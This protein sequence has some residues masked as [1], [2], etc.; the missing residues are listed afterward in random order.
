MQPALDLIGGHIPPPRW[1]RGIPSR[2]IKF[3]YDSG[4][5]GKG[6]ACFLPVME[7][8]AANYKSDEPGDR[9]TPGFIHYNQNILGFFH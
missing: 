9:F 3:G 7:K 5:I 2:G 4:R 1:C 6:P 8:E